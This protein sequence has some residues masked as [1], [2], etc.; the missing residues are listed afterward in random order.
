MSKVTFQT[1]ATPTLT[2]EEFKTKQESA[3]GKWIKDPGTYSL[4]IK[5][6]EMTGASQYD[7]Q[8]VNFKFTME[9]SEGQLATH[10]VEVPTTAAN[11]YM[12][13]V[14]KSLGNYSKLEKFLKGF[15]FD[16]EFTQAIHQLE[17]L[18]SDAEKT[19]I[20]KTFSARMGYTAIHTKYL[21]KDGEVSQ[22]QIVDRDGNPIVADKFAGFEAVDAY[23]KANNIKVQG[24][25]KIL[26]VVPASTATIV[27]GGPAIASAL[28]F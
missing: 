16:L 5:G 2:P 1:A 15:G 24:F 9:N 22:Y 13:G 6:V 18:F 21:G 7:N 3:G 19:F 23:A 28:P 12:Y 11:N 8:W 17:K 25:P 26:E 14:K 20:G 4:I 27:I 10:Y